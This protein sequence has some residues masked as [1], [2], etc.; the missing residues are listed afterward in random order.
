MGKI[1]ALME[2]SLGK[3]RGAASLDSNGKLKQM[4]T[5]AEVGAVSINNLANIGEESTIAQTITNLVNAGNRKG[6]FA[7]CN[8]ADMPHQ[9]YKDYPTLIEFSHI[10]G[11][12]FSVVASVQFVGTY[13]AQ[14]NT[15]SGIWRHPW[16][17]LAT[18]DYA[19]PRDGSAA[20]NGKL[21]IEAPNGQIGSVGDNS[22]FRIDG[23]SSYD[24][25]A[26]LT[27]HGNESWQPGH[28]QLVTGGAN[29]VELCGRGDG[30][31]SWGGNDVLHT[32][33]KPSGS[34]TGN[35]S[36]T[37]RTIA[38]GGIGKC[39]MVYGGTGEVAYLVPIGAFFQTNGAATFTSDVWF[40]NGVIYL[41]NAYIINMNGITYNY[42]V[43]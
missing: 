24:K 8:C 43:L 25:G 11:D 7:A 1:K 15:Y 37:E 32:G 9:E 35:G 14:Y 17:Q 34:Y 20:M 4:P 40:D 30:H 21:F 42:Q 12:D 16:K 36:S 18:T 10:Q 29:R 39:C 3:P 28:F 23:G 19:L 33:N 5:A 13:E 41:R 27:L 2:T 26:F 38:T 6:S 22:A 31:L